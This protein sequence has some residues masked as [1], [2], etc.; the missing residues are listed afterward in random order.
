MSSRAWG[1]HKEGEEFFLVRAGPLGCALISLFCGNI[2]I[3][4]P[5]GPL[6]SKHPKVDGMPKIY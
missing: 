4:K 5:Q 3:P 6:L 2:K 1:R